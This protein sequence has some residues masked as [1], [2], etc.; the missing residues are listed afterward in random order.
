MR[1]SRSPLTKYKYKV[2][3]KNNNKN[4]GQPTE[5]SLYIVRGLP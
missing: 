1:G 4:F 2:M 5:K 3:N